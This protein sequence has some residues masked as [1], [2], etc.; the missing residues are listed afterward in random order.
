MQTIF[1]M[2]KCDLGKA[3]EVANPDVHVIE[4]FTDRKGR[5][6]ATGLR[7]GLWRI[8]LGAGAYSYDLNV[9]AAPTFQRQTTPLEPRR[10][11]Q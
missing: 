4:L 10:S 2:V 3:Y 5:F 9:S 6:A 8:E 1:V 7:P 11:T